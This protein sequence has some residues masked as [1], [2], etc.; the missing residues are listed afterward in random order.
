MLG[1]GVG[2]LEAMLQ[3][4][5]R[6]EGIGVYHPESFGESV[7]YRSAIRIDTNDPD[8][9]EVMGRAADMKG[10]VELLSNDLS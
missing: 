10:K 3:A 1:H 2:L 6:R 4:I 7:H 5:G 8:P 9:Y